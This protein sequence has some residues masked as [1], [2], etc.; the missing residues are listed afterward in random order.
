M[1][2]MAQLSSETM[3]EILEA[4]FVSASLLVRQR[5][6]LNCGRRGS[7]KMEEGASRDFRSTIIQEGATMARDWFRKAASG[8]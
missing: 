4:T 8:F 6:D 3:T 1:Q 2:W 5:C 7:D